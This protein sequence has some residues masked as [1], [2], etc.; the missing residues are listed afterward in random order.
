MA[1]E[2]HSSLVIGVG[3]RRRNEPFRLNLCPNLERRRL[4][5]GDVSV[6]FGSKA[7]F[8]LYQTGQEYTQQSTPVFNRERFLP[9]ALPWHPTFA[10]KSNFP[11]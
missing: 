3:K 4:I 7:A 9:R 2:E 10:S 11:S 6:A 1:S 5:W 8:S